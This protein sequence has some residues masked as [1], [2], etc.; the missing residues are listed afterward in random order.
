MILKNTLTNIYRNSAYTD[1]MH[2]LIM[3]AVAVVPGTC[4]RVKL[5]ALQR[6]F[7]R[8]IA[9]KMVKQRVL[10]TLAQSSTCSVSVTLSVEGTAIVNTVRYS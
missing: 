9:I 7:S 5:T 6:A 3:Q 4:F 8:C 10:S 2:L 1:E